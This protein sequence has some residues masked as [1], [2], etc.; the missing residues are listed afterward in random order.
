[1]L[2]II[3]NYNGITI[4][5][6]GVDALTGVPFMSEQERANA[7]LIS[8]TDSPSG[9]HSPE[10]RHSEDARQGQ[11]GILDYDTFV[12][13]RALVFTGQLIAPDRETMVALVDKFQKAFTPSAVPSKDDG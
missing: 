10:L 1:M 4:N 12:G 2:G 5:N 8:L 7:C 13:K 6:L 11:H 3:Y 9:F